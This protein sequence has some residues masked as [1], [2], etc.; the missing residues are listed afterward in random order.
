MCISRFRYRRVGGKDPLTVADDLF[1][2]SLEDTKKRG[3]DSRPLNLLLTDTQLGDHST[4]AVDVLLGQIVQQ[5]AALTDHHQQTTAGVVVV[6]VDAQMLGQ[7]VDTGS[8]DGDLNLGGTGVALVG[9]VFRRYFSA[10]GQWP[11]SG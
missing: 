9:R 7:L 1:R 8:Q 3:D 10:S 2:V 4:V 11:D 6:L 5:T